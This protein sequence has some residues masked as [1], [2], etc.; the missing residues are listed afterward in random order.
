[1]LSKYEFDMEHWAGTKHGNTDAS[2]RG[3]KPELAN[4]D[5]R[6]EEGSIQALVIVLPNDMREQMRIVDGNN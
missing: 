6:D 4:P 2:S 1:M 3:G 5:D